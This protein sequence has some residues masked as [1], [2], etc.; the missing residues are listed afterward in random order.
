VDFGSTLREWRID[1]DLSLRELA[2]KVRMDFT[3]LSKIETGVLAPPADDRIRDL[4]AALGRHTQD[5]ETLIDMARRSSV[6]KDV[7]RAALI[8][9]PEVGALLRTLKDRRLSQD[10]AEMLKRWAT[11]EE[12]H[13][14]ASG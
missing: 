13:G 5:A 11:E 14:P 12:T 8:K 6:P 7:V 1:A 10:Q 2:R 3:Q 4:V 9:N